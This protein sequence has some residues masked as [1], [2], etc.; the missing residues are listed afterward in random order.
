MLSS[1]ASGG[2]EAEVSRR[3]A[4]LLAHAPASGSLSSREDGARHAR[5]SGD[6]LLL[7]SYKPSAPLRA[8]RPVAAGTEDGWEEDDTS[9]T[10]FESW[11]RYFLDGGPSPLQKLVTGGSSRASDSSA[12]RVY[13][14]LR[15][16]DE[17]AD[18]AVA[19]G[20]YFLNA[21]DFVEGALVL[22]AIVERAGGEDADKADD[23]GDPKGERRVYFRFNS[24]S[25]VIRP[26]K[27]IGALMS[28]FPFSGGPG[29]GPAPGEPLV[30]IPYFVP[31]QLLT[32][33]LPDETL[34]YLD[35]VYVDETLR[36]SIG[37]RGTAFVLK[38]MP[39]TDENLEACDGEVAESLQRIRTFLEEYT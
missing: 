2:S 15:L 13:Q 19:E 38:R 5:L 35:T 4:A 9:I 22:E 21:V 27:A 8:L 23:G 34:G 10:S 20:G 17:M 3:I 18:G 33:V 29:G 6:W 28:T 32:R 39:E 24:G 25:F 30:R 31:F 14:R 16:P 7:K 11:R 12:V 37:N 1:C 26:P 36:I